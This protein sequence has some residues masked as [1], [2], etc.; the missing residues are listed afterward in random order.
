MRSASLRVR[1]GPLRSGA[2]R[3]ESDVRGVVVLRLSGAPSLVL[4]DCRGSLSCRVVAGP[5][6]RGVGR[7]AGDLRSSASVWAEGACRP[8]G[9]PDCKLDGGS[10]GRTGGV[11]ARRAADCH[12]ARDPA[13]AQAGISA[14]AVGSASAMGSASSGDVLWYCTES[15]TCTVGAGAPTSYAGFGSACREGEPRRSAW[16]PTCGA[17]TSAPFPSAALRSARR[18]YEPRRAAWSGICRAGAG[19]R[20]LSAELGPARRG[21]EPERRASSGTCRD[22]VEAPFLSAGFR[23][24]GRDDGARRWDGSPCRAP[25]GTEFAGELAARTPSP[26]GVL[27]KFVDMS[28]ISSADQVWLVPL[29]LG[30]DVGSRCP[31]AARPPAA[32]RRAAVRCG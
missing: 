22:G 24:T 5:P 31:S 25:S 7:L 28:D 30:S 14:G 3:L 18:E 15:A 16:S 8:E 32:A 1:A 27:G 19:A 10:A 26:G 12:G 11:A 23:S 29:L 2:V 21:D 6:L 4:A 9:P 17:E 13:D 20:F